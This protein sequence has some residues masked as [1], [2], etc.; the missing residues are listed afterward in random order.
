M[1][2]EGLAGV[3]A[4]DEMHRQAKPGSSSAKPSG[5]LGKAP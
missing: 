2:Q 3:M 5:S 4:P 1:F